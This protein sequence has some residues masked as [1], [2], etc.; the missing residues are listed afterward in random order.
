M[1]RGGKA[2]RH[3]HALG[4]LRDHFAERGILAAYGL[5]IRH[6]QFFKRNDQSGRFEQLRHGKLQS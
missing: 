6:S 3:A 5:D 4:Q 2:G 1:S